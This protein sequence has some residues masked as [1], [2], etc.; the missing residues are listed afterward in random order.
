MLG[1]VQSE[2]SHLAQERWMLEKV[3]QAYLETLLFEKPGELRH[4]EDVSAEVEEGR[5]ELEGCL[6]TGLAGLC[7][8][9]TRR[10]TAGQN[11]VP[12]A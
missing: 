11:L 4:V 6:G 1:V 7:V 12:R 3:L 2:D 8:N 5:V 10:G 9:Q